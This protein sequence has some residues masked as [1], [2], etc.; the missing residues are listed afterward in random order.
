MLKAYDDNNTINQALGFSENLRVICEVNHLGSLNPRVIK[1]NQLIYLKHGLLN[2]KEITENW[3][4]G[5]IDKHHS[6]SLMENSINS[7]AAHVYDPLLDFIKELDKNSGLIYF[8][9]K[10]GVM[11]NL[12]SYIE[13]FLNELRKYL[14]IHDYSQYFYTNKND[15][16]AGDQAANNDGNSPTSSN[17]NT[18]N[19][20]S[21]PNLINDGLLNNAKKGGIQSNRSISMMTARRSQRQSVALLPTGDKMQDVGNIFGTVAKNDKDGNTVSTRNIANGNVRRSSRV[22][23]CATTFAKLGTKD[24]NVTNNQNIPGS[25]RENQETQASVL[26]MIENRVQAIC[27]FSISQFLLSL[28]KKNCQK[29]FL[30]KLYDVCLDYIMLTKKNPASFGCGFFEI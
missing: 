8:T 26:E 11:K 7:M 29:L 16:A 25:A 23:G 24:E 13:V 2:I 30:N 17:K 10:N 28:V 18:T 14:Y 15:I 9:S 27:M 6:F 5:L 21:N 22:I 20:K 19:R 12:L 1:E 3:I 4:K